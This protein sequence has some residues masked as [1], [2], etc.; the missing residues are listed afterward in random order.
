[1]PVYSFVCPTCGLRFDEKMSFQ[2]D[3]HSAT[4]PKGH[5]GAR[6]VFSAPQVVFKGSGFYITDHRK[7]GSS[8]S[9]SK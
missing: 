8:E 3:A 2:Q 7:G 6:R 1:M 9:A 5:E 4:C